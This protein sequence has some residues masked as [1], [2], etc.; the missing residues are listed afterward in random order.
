MTLDEPIPSFDRRFSDPAAGPAAWHDVRR[1]LADAELYWL[2]TVRA[3]GR[4][5][6]TPL[7]GVVVDGCAHFVT[8]LAEQKARNL[9]HERRVALVTGTNAWTAGTD[10]VVEGTAA[11]VT[12][13]ATLTR[14]ADAYDAKYAGAWHFEVGDGVLR[15]HDVSDAAVFRVDPSKV[16]AFAKDPH[17]QTSFRFER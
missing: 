4:P 7:V 1:A 9:E 11:R 5:H 16:L 15:H 8:G 3:D 17:G 6:V 2:S 14:I 12:D 10:I 13:T